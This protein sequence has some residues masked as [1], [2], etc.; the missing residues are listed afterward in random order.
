[1]HDLRSGG[2]NNLPSKELVVLDMP[3]LKAAVVWAQ[4]SCS[5]R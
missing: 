3:A 1:M 4:F 5:G 2:S